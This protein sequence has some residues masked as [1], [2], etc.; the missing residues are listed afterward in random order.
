MCSD[1]TEPLSATEESLH[2]ITVFIQMTIIG[3]LFGAVAARGNHRGS[4]SC[5]EQRHERVGVIALVG[6]YRLRC[7]THNQS[8][9]FSDISDL[10]AG[11]SA[12]QRIAQGIDRR[13]NLRAQPAVRTP[14]TRANINLSLIPE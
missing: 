12:T 13:M 5:I 4:A 2:S 8:G 6:D 7:E 11:E 14:G 3:S 9:R 10:F 1:T